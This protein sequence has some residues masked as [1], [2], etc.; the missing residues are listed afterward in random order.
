MFK[1]ISPIERRNGE[2]YWMRLGSAF[3]NKDDSINVYL[4][5][6]PLGKDFHLQLRELTEE[7]L[8]PRGDRNGQRA[9]FNMPSNASPPQPALSMP[10]TNDL[11]F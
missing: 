11:P 5:A 10:T 2:K 1:V 9:A 4:D 8:A 7:D 3:T 6:M